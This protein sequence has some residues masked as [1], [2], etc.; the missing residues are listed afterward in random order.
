MKSKSNRNIAI[1]RGK[2][3]KQ[4]R[5]AK[6]YSLREFS[7]LLG[8]SSSA[9]TKVEKGQTLDCNYRMIDHMAALLGVSPRWLEYGEKS[10]SIVINKGKSQTLI[11]DL[12]NSDT[13]KSHCPLFNWENVLTKRSFSNS[14]LFYMDHPFVELISKGG[15]NSFAIKLDGPAMIGYDPIT[16]DSY[17]QNDLLYFDPDIEIFENCYICAEISNEERAV[18]R[19]F[20]RDCANYYLKPLNPQFH[21]IEITKKIK[22]LGVL[23]YRGTFFEK[24]DIA[25]HKLKSNANKEMV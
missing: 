1:E 8:I 16:G 21:V 4:A 3:I 18:F 24:P 17:K 23:Y 2:R 11:E 7:E 5:L 13:I 22:I 14:K 20:V 19:Q 10:S 9:F 12:P 15:Q 25:I 6:N